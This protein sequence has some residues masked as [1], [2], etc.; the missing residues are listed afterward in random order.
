MIK[1]LK[2]IFLCNRY[3]VALKTKQ[4]VEAINTNLKQTIEKYHKLITH[5]CPGKRLPVIEDLMMHPRAA[6]PLCMYLIHY[7]SV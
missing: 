1:T 7:K 3:E 5:V 6:H 2:R 4:E